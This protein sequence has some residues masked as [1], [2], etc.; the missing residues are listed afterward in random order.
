MGDVTVG[1]SVS[2]I[3]LNYIYMYAIVPVILLCLSLSCICCVSHACFLCHLTR[4]LFPVSGV[5][6]ADEI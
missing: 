5:V 4:A 3:G 2:Y 1:V 6:I